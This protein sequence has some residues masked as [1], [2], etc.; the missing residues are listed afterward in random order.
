MRK[1]IQIV[2]DSDDDITALCDDGTVWIWS[3]G[4]WRVRFPAIPQDNPQE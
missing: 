1:I 4:G 3:M 2:N